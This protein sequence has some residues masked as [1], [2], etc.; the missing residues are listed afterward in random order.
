MHR[1]SLWPS[2]ITAAVYLALA[3]FYLSAAHANF[4]FFIHFPA[5][6]K[7]TR[8]FGGSEAGLWVGDYGH[9]GISYYAIA[10]EPF[11]I[12]A[13]A[14]VLDAPLLRYRRILYPLLAHLLSF[15]YPSLIPPVMLLLNL[16][17]TLLG[18][19]ILQRLIAPSGL[20]PGWTLLYSLHPGM[21]LSFLS[22]LPTSLALLGILLALLCWRRGWQVRTALA[23][24]AATLTWEVVALPVLLG[25]WGYEGLR[26]FSRGARCR[27]LSWVLSLPLAVGLGWE[28]VLKFLFPSEMST[29]VL[30]N[31]VFPPISGWWQVMEYLPAAPLGSRKVFLLLFLGLVATS[32]VLS[33][34]KFLMTGS[35]LATLGMA[36]ALLV[37]HLV[38]SALVWPIEISR[39]SLGLWLFTFL[40]FSE[41]SD[42]LRRVVLLGTLAATFC[43]L[44]WLR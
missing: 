44:P 11:N 26:C 12:A 36:Q 27:P 4:T 2:V 14:E 7:V 40:T 30:L 3:G 23:L 1:L 10:R 9:D 21:I 31:L 37:A 8:Y 5:E 39:K 42:L 19:Y 32:A 24:S 6:N 35:L 20:A 25:W 34:Y 22:D 43:L 17:A 13:L 38:P 28:V 33:G 41:K 15:G 16:G 29:G 18:G